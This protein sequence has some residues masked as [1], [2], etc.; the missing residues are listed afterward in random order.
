MRRRSVADLYARLQ[1]VAGHLE[2]PRSRRRSND[3]V[4]GSDAWGSRLGIEHVQLEALLTRYRAMQHHYPFVVI[5]QEWT[6]SKMLHERPCL[7]LAAVSNAASQDPDLQESLAKE[8]K[9]SFAQQI[10]SENLSS[11]DVLQALLVHLAW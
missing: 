3:A 6:V 10:V 4:A 11:L 5:A 2:N 9:D 7:L 1:R 8:L